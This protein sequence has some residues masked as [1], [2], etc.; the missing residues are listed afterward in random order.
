MARNGGAVLD[1]LTAM[2][3]AERRA[4][5]AAGRA[6]VL[7]SHTAVHRAAELERYIAK[8]ACREG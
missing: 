7:A 6:R 8:V 1:A 4:V 2:P 5:G 3:E